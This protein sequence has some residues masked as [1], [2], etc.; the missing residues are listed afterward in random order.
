MG[1]WAHCSGSDIRVQHSL[2]ACARV[3]PQ[4]GQKGHK[5]RAHNP[6]RGLDLRDSAGAQEVLRALRARLTREARGAEEWRDLAGPRWAPALGAYVCAAHWLEHCLREAAGSLVLLDTEGARR[7]CEGL[8]LGLVQGVH[9]LE[10]CLREAAGP[11]VLL[12]AEGARRAC[13]GLGYGL[14]QGVHRLER[15]LH[16]AA[17]PRARRRRG[18]A[19]RAQVG[20]GAKSFSCRP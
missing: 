13:E 5:G 9:R 15:C 4:K 14:V 11:L 12:D 18:G 8:G 19:P 3:V 1:V 2:P 20:A 7:A 6:V 17:G 16:E 10:R